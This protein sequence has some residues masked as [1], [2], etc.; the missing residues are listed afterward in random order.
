MKGLEIIGLA[1]S[2]LN[3]E[4]ARLYAISSKKFVKICPVSPSSFDSDAQ[5]ATLKSSVDRVYVIVFATI[6][7]TTPNRHGNHADTFD[8]KSRQGQGIVAGKHREWPA[9]LG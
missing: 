4:S 5:T 6:G 7:N 1:N 3:M 8:G 2:S 9:K